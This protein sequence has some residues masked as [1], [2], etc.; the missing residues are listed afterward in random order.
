[1]TL[2][3]N[4]TEDEKIAYFKELSAKLIGGNNIKS[5]KNRFN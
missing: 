1:M 3:P 2:S 5:S 4:A